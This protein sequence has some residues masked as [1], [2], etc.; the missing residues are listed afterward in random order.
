MLTALA[1]ASGRRYVHAALKGIGIAAWLFMTTGSR[2]SA[3]A[4]LR[5]AVAMRSL[6]VV[7]G[8]GNAEPFLRDDPRWAELMKSGGLSR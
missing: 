2:D 8:L 6:A 7:P 3:F 5:Q 4:R 1:A